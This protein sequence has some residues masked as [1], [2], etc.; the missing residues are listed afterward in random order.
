MGCPSSSFKELDG[1]NIECFNCRSQWF[2]N[3]E[4]GRPMVS[5]TKAGRDEYGLLLYKEKSLDFWGNM[6]GISK[7]AAKWRPVLIVTGL[8][9]GALFGF[10]VMA[11]SFAIQKWQGDILVE[12]TYPYIGYSYPLMILAILITIVGVTCSIIAGLLGRRS[13]RPQIY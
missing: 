11:S 1:D 3:F 7:G 12:T 10:S 2:F 5:L 8:I 4:S 9:A 13:R 6:G